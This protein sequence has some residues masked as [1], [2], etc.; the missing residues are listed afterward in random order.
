MFY[1]LR[2][3]A[4]YTHVSQLVDDCFSD[5]NRQLLARP[6]SKSVAGPIVEKIDSTPSCKDAYHRLDDTHRVTSKIYAIKRTAF[7]AVLEN[8]RLNHYVIDH[9]DMLQKMI[10][11]LHK[12]YNTPVVRGS[13]FAS[14]WHRTASSSLSRRK[15]DARVESAQSEASVRRGV[16]DE[17]KS[18]LDTTDAARTLL[19]VGL[20]CAPLSHCNAF[21][22]VS[23]SKNTS[24]LAHICFQYMLRH[25]S[26]NDKDRSHR[27]WK[28]VLVKKTL[29]FTNGASHHR[30]TPREAANRRQ[31]PPC[32]DSIVTK[33]RLL[34]FLSKS[35]STVKYYECIT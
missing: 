8:L 35:N 2:A 14:S 17:Y 11:E 21:V 20:F 32:C 30:T 31:P 25:R 23:R 12:K 5:D 9:I 18:K 27:L 26:I 16:I 28:V 15:D 10:A 22:Q 33:L 6:A 13:A 7:D 4:P 34:C 3:N 1:D 29:R 24:R 19:Y